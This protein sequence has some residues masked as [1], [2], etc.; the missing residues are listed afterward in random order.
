M[1]AV[2]KQPDWIGIDPA[3]SESTAAF[4]F[5]CH[6]CGRHHN[7]TIGTIPDGWAAPY[8]P[9]T[10]LLCPDCLATIEQRKTEEIRAR[11]Q[12]A[13]EGLIFAAMA[14]EIIDNAP[15]IYIFAASEWD[16]MNEDGKLWLTAIVR[17]AY[18][19]GTEAVIKIGIHPTAPRTPSWPGPFSLHLQRQDDGQYLIAM[20]PETALMRLSPLEFFLSPEGARTLAWHLI[21]HADLA[22]APGTLPASVGEGK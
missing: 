10:I 3:K 13:A 19:R 17:E 11:Q 15:V 6:N 5:I 7:S 9:K 16:E 1:N 14:K 22:D 8:L 21:R 2:E 4:T 12:R 18:K 20:T